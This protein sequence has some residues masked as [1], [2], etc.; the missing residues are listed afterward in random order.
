VFG[1]RKTKVP[2]ASQSYEPPMGVGTFSTVI[3]PRSAVEA[4]RDPATANRLATALVRFVNAMT[5][6]G[7]YTRD[8]LLLKATQAF[9]ADYYLAQ[10]NNGGHAQ[11]IHNSMS[12]VDFAL[13]DVLAA[14]AALQTEPYTSIG[15]R[16]AAWAGANRDP[17]TSKIDLKRKDGPDVLHEL[18]MA[19]YAADKEQPFQNLLG[20]WIAGWP[21]LRAV[22]DADYPEAM[23]ISATLNPLREVRLLW[24]SVSH[25][26]WQ[27]TD[28]LQVGSGLACAHIQQPEI[29]LALGAGIGMQVDGSREI[30]FTVRTNE[31]QLRC[32]VVKPE[33]A[34]A[35]EY[36]PA[37]IPKIPNLD[38]DPDVFIKAMNDGKLKDI[39]EPAAGP[40]LSR[41]DGKLIDGVIELGKEQR[42]ALAIDLLLRTSGIETRNAAVAALMI[43]MG[44]TGPFVRWMLLAGNQPLVASTSSERS[45]LFRWGA[46]EH[47]VSVGQKDLD[48]HDSRVA[49]GNMGAK[50]L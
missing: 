7:L 43:A 26:R 48:A 44:S 8:E 25:L 4:A 30:A 38:T 16:L 39:K 33:H 11:F 18:D 6:E 46:T 40:R 49:A 34:S 31:A 14:T 17:A 47:F 41:V 29:R 36:I 22:D 5:G 9:H 1:K 42:A 2:S 10:V 24:K 20:R 12:N 35:Y 13:A 15:A 45:A 23:R 3:V 32:C 28:R 21:E 19:F 27:M 50:P 37:N